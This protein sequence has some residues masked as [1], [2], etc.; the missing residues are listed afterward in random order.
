VPKVNP[1]TLLGTH[2]DGLALAAS[3]FGEFDEDSPTIWVPK[4]VSGLTF[5]TNGFYLNYEDSAD[6]GADVSGNSNDF[7]LVNIAAADMSQDSPTNNFSTMNPL[8]LSSY[9]ALSNGN[10]TSSRLGAGGDNGNVTSTMAPSAGKWYAEVKLTILDSTGT[11]YPATG[12]MQIN[13]PQFGQLKNSTAGMTGYSAS[14][15]D[16]TPNGKLRV[17]NVETSSWGSAASAG[18]ILGIAVDCDNGAAYSALN[19]TWNNSG[20]P[21]SGASKTGAATTWT[22]ADSD[23]IVFGSADYGGS[24][25][26]WNLGNGCFGDTVVTSAEADGNGYGLFEYAPPSGYL[27]VCTKNLGSDGG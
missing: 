4:R 8:D 5:G 24:L 16:L 20:D 13:S 14:S 7:T 18:D 3:D 26:D 23:G 15:F 1:E 6:L 10:N 9:E 17:N 19:N 27:A 21:T 25:G 12:M 2:I 11:N 22:P